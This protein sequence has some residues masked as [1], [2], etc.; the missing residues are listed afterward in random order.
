MKFHYHCLLISARTRL[1]RGI[2]DGSD[3]AFLRRAVWPHPHRAWVFSRDTNTWWQK[4]SD[5]EMR[6]ISVIKAG[7]QLNVSS[8]CSFPPLWQ[9]K[10]VD[11]SDHCMKKVHQELSI[12]LL[13]IL[14]KFNDI[15]SWTKIKSGL[16]Q[17]H[18]VKSFR[19]MTIG[20]G[21]PSIPKSH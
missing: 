3:C 5:G 11:D 4:C 20:I 15:F 21:K 7:T 12:Y 6:L 2:Q 9:G 8:F 14:S 19:E 10:N 1:G 18:L 16:Y 13:I 17:L